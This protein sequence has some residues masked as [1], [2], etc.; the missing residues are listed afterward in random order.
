MKVLVGLSGGVDSAV[1]ALRL[2]ELGHEVVGA[3][4]KLWREGIYKGGDAGSCFGP[5]EADSIAAA[6]RLA[7]TLDIPYHIFDCFDAYHRNVIEYFRTTYLSGR[8]PNPCVQC[9]AL[10][11][12]GL[13]PRLAK[14]NGV[15]FDAFATGHYARIEQ[16]GNRFALL[17]ARDA[18]KDQSYFLYR[19]S[20]E[21]LA[22]QIFPLGD[23]TKDEVR[24]IANRATLPNANR[25]DS[26]DFYSGDKDELIGENDRPGNIVDS[27]GKIVGTH[28]GFWR[29]TIGQRK[30][31]GIAST[32]PYY[33]IDLNACRNE[34]VVG[35]INDARRNS[36]SVNELNFVSVSSITACE[37][38]CKVRSAAKPAT[39]SVTYTDGIAHVQSAEGIFGIAP[40]QSAV[41]YAPTDGSVLFG[42]VII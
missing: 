41:F 13:L 18:V 27:T 6:S 39:V 33:V 22:R 30:G 26:Q 25:P 7:Q 32:E 37:C 5:G 8:T 1:A 14:E 16:R 4:M 15:T 34:V 11:K 28:R 10:V 36:F 17:T 42:G 20:Q 3:T 35:R 2:K 31:L 24:T 29:Y 38:L 12:F 19:L 23:L 21:Q 9:N 40:G